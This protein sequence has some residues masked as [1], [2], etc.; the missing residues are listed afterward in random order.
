MK[1]ITLLILRFK[2]LLL[3]LL[4]VV[5]GCKTVDKTNAFVESL[6]NPTTFPDV[7]LPSVEDIDDIVKKNGLTETEDFKIVPIGSNKN[8]NVY[9]MQFRKKAVMEAHFHKLHD[10]V[11]Y[12]KKG[13]G[14]IEMDG[15]RTVVKE[16]M[17]VFIP[18]KTVHRF[19]NVG[20]ELNT[21]ISIFSPPFD[22]S[23]M[24]SIKIEKGFK[25][26][27]ETIYDKAMRKSKKDF[28]AE[29]GEGKKWFGLL[30]GDEKKIEF[31]EKKLGQEGKVA[32]EQKVLVLTDEGK[33]KIKEVQRKVSE[34]ERKMIKR[35]IVN[36]K[37]KVLQKLK[38]E[39][40]LN[41]EEFDDK[42]TELINESEG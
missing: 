11:M 5:S 25:K 22:G 6:R 12:I 17:V 2:Y 34:E 30:K 16:G 36:E 38:D 20:E 23:D 28:K 41:Q 10:E 1:N 18:R 24:N 42:R 8:I 3:V 15:T 13:T 19:V 32:G 27:K 14:I 35:M 21:S 9:L 26:K 4:A 40:L 37:L 39:G 7:F 33:Q 31:D 29:S